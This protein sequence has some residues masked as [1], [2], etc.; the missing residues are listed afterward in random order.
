MNTQVAGWYCD[1]AAWALIGR[2]YLP[3]LVMLNLAW[4]VAQLP[5]YTLW[6][7][8]PPAYMALAVAHCTAGDAVIGAAALAVAL[9]VT[10]APGLA[11]W[12]WGRIAV[13]ATLAA[14]AYTAFSEWMNTMAT[15]NWTYSELMPVLHV[16]GLDL[17]LGPLAQWL[18]LPPL[19]L[20]I[21]RPRDS[22]AFG[23][24]AGHQ[25]N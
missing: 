23:I 7:N 14:V 17:G 22:A 11:R 9:I 3:W 12:R 20:W 15:R 13:L 4:E 18:L 21:A 24:G 19:A 16:A 8:A 10:R 2:R 25:R 5:L 1:R 6:T